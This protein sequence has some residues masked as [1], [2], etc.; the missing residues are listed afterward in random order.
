MTKRKTP[1]KIE[2]YTPPP[3]PSGCA[4]DL[5][6]HGYEVRPDGLHC[7]GQWMCAPIVVLGQSHDGTGEKWG[8]CLTFKDKDG[9]SKRHVIR[10]GA[11]IGD[12][13]DAIEALADAGLHI[14]PGASRKLKAAL[15]MIDPPARVCAVERSGWI[16]EPGGPYMHGTEAIVPPPP[17]GMA[18][19]MFIR[20]GEAPPMAKA[21]TLEGWRAAVCVP[22]IGNTRLVLAVCAGFAGPALAVLGS[23]NIGLHLR[24]DSSRG[25]STAL[26]VAASVG[27]FTVAT[28]RAT[29]NGL[30][31]LA[32]G[33]NDGLLILDELGEVAGHEV[34]PTVY[35]LGNGEGKARATRN[36]EASRRKKWGA[37][38]LSSGEITVAQKQAEAGVKGGTRAG[39]EVRMIDIEA[40]PGKG[41]GLFESLPDGQSASGFADGLKAAAKRD[42][43]Q[44]L[45]AFVRAIQA[46]G[47][48]ALRALRKH[49]TGLFAAEWPHCDGQAVRVRQHFSLLATVG[50][51][52]TESDLTGWPR[53]EAI[54][55][56]KACFEAW[57]APRAHGSHESRAAIERVK[58]FV[59]AHGSARFNVTPEDDDRERPTILRAGW[60][61]DI[62]DAPHYCVAGEI[63][64][65]EVVAGMDPKAAARALRDA[66]LLT[67]DKT[68]LTK[69]IRIPGGATPRTFAVNA[70]ILNWGGG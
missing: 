12:R 23:E 43:G 50:E 67:T 60:L 22:C 24:G 57:L 56:A 7:N 69:T 10:R 54:T 66:G 1:A 59:E 42:C 32:D 52:A 39:Q 13:L 65:S 64:K 49:V 44:A 47:G 35:M 28:W 19:E 8:L 51:F 21:G 30:E 16:G 40:D 11:L 17:P 36:G 45:P 29:G 5:W 18:G 62:D 31:G 26:W 6:P 20:T 4:G 14:A 53:G 38:V 27:G 3:G 9:R 2:P 70:K 63:W 33:A 68:A 41:L 55:A 58:G 25:K 46:D 37:V 34:G 48:E 15:A 61:R